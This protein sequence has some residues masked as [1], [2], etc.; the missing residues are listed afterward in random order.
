[1]RETWVPNASPLIVLAKIGRLDLLE[2]E[3][4]TLIVPAEVAEEVRRGPATDPARLAIERGWGGSPVREE[5]DA[6]VLEWGLGAGE[7]AVLGVARR[8][9]AV[10]VLD[11]GEARAAARVLGCQVI[12]TLG[13]VLRA[14]VR[15][16]IASA[17]DVLHALVRAGFRLDAAV[18]RAA[19]LRVCGEPWTE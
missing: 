4:R 6:E 9:R 10:A 5:A 12:G 7:S 13:V 2:E 15:G 19:L 1:M 18:V 8:S 17:A 14:R 11:D 16:R 3:G